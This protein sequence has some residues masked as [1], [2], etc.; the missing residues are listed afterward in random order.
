MNIKLSVKKNSKK[1][2]CYDRFTTNKQK[3]KIAESVYSQIGYKPHCDNRWNVE[4]FDNRSR[5]SEAWFLANVMIPFMLNRRTMSKL[6]A[7]YIWNS[8]PL[9]FAYQ[10]Y[11]ADT[12]KVSLNLRLSQ[13]GC[14]I[15]SYTYRVQLK[16][17]NFREHF[18][19][20]TWS[21]HFKMNQIL[22]HL[23]L[24]TGET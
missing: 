10:N 9:M 22:F 21:R 13:C 3:S 5:Y 4:T 11:K 17:H 16:N 12:E 8:Y 14:C 1:G 2:S 18:S 19:L 23:L 6:C 20:F 7:C 24:V 15:N